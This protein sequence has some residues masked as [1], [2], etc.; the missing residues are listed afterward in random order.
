MKFFLLTG[1]PTPTLSIHSA[2]LQTVSDCFSPDQTGNCL[3]EALQDPLPAIIYQVR[4]CPSG[5]EMTSIRLSCGCYTRR[6]LRSTY[7]QAH[8][9]QSQGRLLKGPTWLP[10]TPALC[11]LEATAGVRAPDSLQA[12]VVA[13]G[14]K[15]SHLSGA[16]HDNHFPRGTGPAARTAPTGEPKEWPMGLQSR[17]PPSDAVTIGSLFFTTSNSAW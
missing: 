10:V 12:S 8:G 17:T 4:L 11:L 15:A 5:P 1:T 2:M 14:F 6:P 16:H 7:S 13:L 9:A 3:H